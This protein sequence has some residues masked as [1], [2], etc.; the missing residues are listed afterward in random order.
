VEGRITLKSDIIATKVAV[1]KDKSHT[2][3]QSYQELILMQE[4]AEK[5]GIKCLH[6]AISA[7]AKRNCENEGKMGVSKTKCKF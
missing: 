5:T 6:L 7:R 4:E 3:K 1:E 2:K